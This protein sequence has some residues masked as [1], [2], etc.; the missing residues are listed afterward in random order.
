MHSLN[1]SIFNL[2]AL[3]VK[4]A[5]KCGCCQPNKATQ[6]S[7][8]SSGRSLLIANWQRPPISLLGRRTKCILARKCRVGPC[9]GYG[10]RTQGG[11]DESS[12]QY[13]CSYL[14]SPSLAACLAV[15]CGYAAAVDAR[16]LAEIQQTGE[17]RFCISPHR[18]F[19]RRTR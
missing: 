17:I 11:H 8:W 18:P 16:S 6:L 14:K 1:K 7:L 10:L 12:N 2:Q 15:A 4:N 13:R 19:L 9:S 5:D 3:F